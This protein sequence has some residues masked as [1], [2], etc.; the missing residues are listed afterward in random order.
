MTL[1]EAIADVNTV[2]VLPCR[3]G[4]HQRTIGLHALLHSGPRLPRQSAADRGQCLQPDN[5]A[6]VRVPG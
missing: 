5:R 1:K 4:Y 3:S 2:R 6:G